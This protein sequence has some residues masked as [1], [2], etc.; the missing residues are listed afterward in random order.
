VT[1]V[2]NFL[3]FALAIAATVPSA[4]CGKPKPGLGGGKPA[5]H[6]VG[7]LQGP[8]PKVRKQAALKLGNIGPSDPAAL[9]ALIGAL[10]DAD[11]GVRREAIL[12]LVKCGPDAR[13]AVG[14]L[15]DLRQ[16]DPDAQ[17]RAYA[18]QAL[19]KIQGGK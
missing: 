4:G 3:L 17:V 7:A 15:A 19:E 9:P 18:A 1:A 5:A 16:R 14:A 11:A 2:R 12:A 13:E 6:W 10:K 8:D